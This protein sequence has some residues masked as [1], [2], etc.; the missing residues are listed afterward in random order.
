VRLGAAVVVSLALLSAASASAAYKPERYIAKYCSPTGDLC[1][2]IFRLKSNDRIVFQI[3]TQERYFAR[4]RVCVKAP[5]GAKTCRN[6]PINS[7]TPVHGSLVYWRRNFGDHGPGVYRVTWS[8]HGTRL[9]PTLR[10]RRR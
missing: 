9:G 2:G 4:Y 7:Q 5:T 3:T 6:F 1:Y 10:F 8:Q